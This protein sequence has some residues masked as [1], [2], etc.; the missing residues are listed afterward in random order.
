MR[1][2][3]TLFQILFFF[4]IIFTACSKTDLEKPMP[5][6]SPAPAGPKGTINFQA[7]V[8]LA[9]HPYH[10][11]NLHAVISITGVNGNEVIK[12]KT[13]T[14]DLSSP[15]K[16][17][18][19]ELPV[20]DYKLT[21]FRLVYG[22]VQTH[23][24]TPFAGSEKAGAVQKPLKLDFKIVKNTLTEIPVELIRVQQC[25]TPQQYGYPS[26]AFDNGQ[27]DADPFL[28]IKMK[29]I[30][31][32]GDVLYD[33]I[34]ASLRITTWNDKG[35]ITT[36]YSS[37]NP[38]VNE[39]QVLKSATKFE[40]LVSK[41][42]TN[43]AITIE[44]QDLDVNTVY[45][46]GGSKESKKLSSERVFKIINGREV[47]DTKTD[48][49]YDIDGN[50][51]KIDYWMKKPDNSNFLSAVEW[52]TYDGGRLS[53]IEK[54]NVENNTVIK[55]TRFTYNAQGKLTNM[56]EKANGFET[57]AAITYLPA[58]QKIGIQYNLAS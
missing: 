57:A 21:G 25:D 5:I 33:H 55:E 41:W 36:T 26:G 2:R 18:I 13:F 22:G 19:I 46:L 42:G 20:G 14:L 39:I 6:P 4:L 45:I 10:T 52:F 49:F 35:E 37:L 11:S 30:M 15:V 58:Q 51:L 38:G 54:V 40:F 43:D 23:F 17:T 29:A 47:A 34:P 56:V 32:I 31:Q 9:G 27:S 12:E 16:T 44:R 1:H 48:Y 24:A 50:L 28:K 3:I 53:K 7:M 8:D